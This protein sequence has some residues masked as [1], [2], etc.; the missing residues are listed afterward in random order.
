MALLTAQQYTTLTG[1][2]APANF[3]TVLPIVV[4]MLERAL[5]RKLE[6]ATRSETLEAYADGLVYPSARPVVSVQGGLTTDGVAI[7]TGQTGPVTVTYLGGFAP[8]GQAAANVLP[9]DLALAICMGIGTFNSTMGGAATS[10]P[11]GV[12]SLSI[13]GEYTVTYQAGVAVGADGQAMPGA[14]V[15]LAPLGGGCARLAAPYRRL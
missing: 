9:P 14:L 7:Q 8:F 15:E 2:A 5:N 4:S 13:A 10:A 3:A 12:Q 6:E 1:L 11:V